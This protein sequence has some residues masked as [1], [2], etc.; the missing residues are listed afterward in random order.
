MERQVVHLVRLVDDLLDIARI[1]QGKIE[2]KKEQV[3]IKTIVDTAVE[4]SRPL[5]EAG[6]HTLSV[7]LPDGSNLLIADATRITQVLSNL[8]NNA[9]KYTPQ[10]GRIA[11]SVRVEKHEVIISVTDNG[12]GIAA[13]SLPMLFEMFTQVGRH[14]SRAQGGL[15]I[16][17]SLV[18]WLVELHGGTVTAS[19]PGIGHGSQFQIRL[20]SGP[21]G[22]FGNAVDVQSTINPAYENASAFRVLIVDDNIDAA[23]TLSALLEIAG[24]QT[25]VAHD[26]YQ[27]LRITEQFNPEVIFLDIGM[28]GMNGYE[29]A[30]A[31]RK[32]P[33]MET[34]SIIA[35]TGWGAEQ[36]RELSKEAGFDAHLTKPASLASVN[37]LLSKIDTPSGSR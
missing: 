25:M 20:P 32:T 13:E 27:G 35:L 26:G 19:S 11:L 14:L 23:Q 24:H 7:D 5:I 30:Q 18:R 37:L 33:G 36:D 3:E 9:A 34:V 29:V 31:V 22:V 12:V 6:H 2:L 8:L 10:G 15:G 17:L 16:G 28:P 21:D 1:T 4:T